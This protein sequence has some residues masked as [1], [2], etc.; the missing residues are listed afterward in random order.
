MSLMTFCG[1]SYTICYEKY[2]SYVTNKSLWIFG[3]LDLRVLVSELKYPSHASDSSTRWYKTDLLHFPPPKAEFLH[4]LYVCLETY[5]S[6][7]WSDLM[8]YWYK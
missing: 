6:T 1:H 2:Y 8:Q 5:L 4:R 7:H 3:S